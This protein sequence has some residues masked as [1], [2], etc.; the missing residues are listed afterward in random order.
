MSEV[1][2]AT[3]AT[4]ATVVAPPSVAPPGLLP[5]ASDTGPVKPV[6][7]LPN[8]SSAATATVNGALCATAGGGC[9]LKTSWAGAAGPMSNGVL[10]AGE[11]PVAVNWTVYPLAALSMERSVNV[12]TPPTAATVNV[13]DSVPAPGFAM[14][15]TV[16]GLVAAGTGFPSASRMDTVTAGAIGVPAVAVV[17]C[18]VMTSIAGTPPVTS[19][20]ALVAPMSP[21]PDAASVYPTPGASSVRSLK[22]ATPPTAATVAVPPRVAPPGFAAIATVTFPV[23]AVT[24]LPK[25]SRTATWT[26][27]AIGWNAATPVGWVTNARTRGGPARPVA[28]AV[29]VPPVTPL[30]VAVM[31]CAP[32]EAP[33]VQVVD[34]SPLASVV[35][36]S[37]DSEPP[38]AVTAK[39]TTTPCTPRLSAARTRATTGSGSAVPTGPLCAS[40]LCTWMAD[41]TGWT[42]SGLVADGG[43]AAEV[44]SNSARMATLPRSCFATTIP[45]SSKGTRARSVSLT[46]N[47]MGVFGMTLLPA[48]TASAVNCAVSWKK[49]VAGAATNRTPTALAPTPV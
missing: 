48:S 2:V 6:A 32:S 35:S 18:C 28:V 19:N 4:A 13:P 15:A 3:P 39:A 44:G 24:V 25:V 20:A 38:P 37:A 26:G 42:T 45:W 14:K 5:K 23:K 16:T 21:V 1:N 17:G 34:A 10:V 40:P 41:G 27:G 11:R 47:R 8:A 33:R 30:A 7:T 49:T 36:T 43:A 29:V 12:A 46:L 22:V 31:A 9:V